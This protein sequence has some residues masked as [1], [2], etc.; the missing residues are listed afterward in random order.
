[1][2]KDFVEIRDYLHDQIERGNL[3]PKEGLEKTDK[4]EYA[5]TMVKIKKTLL[6]F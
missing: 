1:M 3:E 5:K 4:K 2:Y 6:R